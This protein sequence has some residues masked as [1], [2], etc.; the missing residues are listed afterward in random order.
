MASIRRGGPADSEVNVATGPLNSSQ[1]APF[2]GEHPP[3]A[4]VVNAISSSGQ[5]VERKVG[6]MDSYARRDRTG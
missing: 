5:V 1:V 2:L 4:I 6:Q 3:R